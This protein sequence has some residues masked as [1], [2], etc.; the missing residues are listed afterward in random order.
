VEPEIEAERLDEADPFA[1]PFSADTSAALAEPQFA[2]FSPAPR[3]PTPSHAT[4]RLLPTSDRP[5]ASDDTPE[6]EGDMLDVEPPG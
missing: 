6:L 1:E 3:E 5:A 4:T 2:D